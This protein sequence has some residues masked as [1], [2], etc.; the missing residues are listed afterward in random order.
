[1]HHVPDKLPE[2]AWNDLKQASDEREITDFKE[3]RTSLHH[4]IQRLTI[5]S[6][7]CRSLPKPFRT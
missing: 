1:M 3:A 5:S 2:E 6:R 4:S 7:R